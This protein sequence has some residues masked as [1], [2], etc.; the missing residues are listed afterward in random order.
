MEPE[1][2]KNAGEL[3]QITFKLTSDD[4]QTIQETADS[5][6]LN[7]SEYCRL[8]CLADEN[9]VIEQQNQIMRLE[10]EVKHLKVKLAYYK[11]SERTPNDILIKL[12]SDQRNILEKLYADYC[13]P[14]EVSIGENIIQALVC[15]TIFEPI[16]P[17]HK[18]KGFTIEQIYDAFDPYP[19]DESEEE[20]ED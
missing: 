9:A 10:K 17:D 19:E 11:D 3:T 8:K 1:N 7:V 4:R 12:T 2:K 5:L 6:E 16:F 20:Q 13:Y 18:N 15:Y 14:R